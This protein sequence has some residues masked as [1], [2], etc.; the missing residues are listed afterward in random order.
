FK[1]TVSAAFTGPGQL[2]KT[3][4]GLLI[5]TG[6]NSYTG[7]TKVSSGIL[8]LGDGGTAGAI[9]GDVAVTGT[10]AFN[11]SDST[12]FAGAISGGGVVRQIGTG[13]TVLIGDSSRFAGVTQ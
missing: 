5:L 10:L 6:E 4:L 1:A 11:R 7:G 3:D 12:T 13:T 8:Q 2:D 9:Q